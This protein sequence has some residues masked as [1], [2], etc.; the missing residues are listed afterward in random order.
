MKDHT[1][2]LAKLKA[3]AASYVE[4]MHAFTRDLNAS[5][6]AG[7]PD[8]PEGDERARALNAREDA[9]YREARALGVAG[10]PFMGPVH[11]VASGPLSPKA[12]YWKAR[13]AEI[14]DGPCTSNALAWKPRTTR[15]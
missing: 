7:L 13:L 11:E 3:D 9:I 14:G 1:R 12:D 10:D 5:S 2:R 8:V 15:Q 6:A 4:A